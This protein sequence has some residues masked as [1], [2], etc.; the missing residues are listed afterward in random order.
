MVSELAKELEGRVEVIACMVDRICVDR[1]IQ[2]DSIEVKAE[3]Y[4]GEMV[5]LKPP[6]NSLPPPFDGN[7]VN[8]PQL[9]TEVS[10]PSLAH[11]VA[12]HQETDNHHHVISFDHPRPTTSVAASSYW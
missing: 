9:E 6:S 8:M 12:S 2:P 4:R 7:A 3:P 1:V 10:A 5:I 11:I